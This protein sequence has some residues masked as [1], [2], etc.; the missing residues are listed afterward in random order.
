MKRWLLKPVQD[1][2]QLTDVQTRFNYRLSSTRVAIERAFGLLKG[3]FRRLKL[4]D[5][6]SI[7]TAV[8]AI[9]VCCVFHNMCI[10]NE[11]VLEEYIV[12]GREEQYN[13][14]AAEIFYSQ[15]DEDEDGVQ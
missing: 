10:I 5:T 2:S 11:D 7:K 6:K 15:N 4:L 8:D 14:G 9:I 12:D 1:N 13:L 3:R